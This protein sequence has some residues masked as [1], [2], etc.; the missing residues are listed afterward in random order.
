MDDREGG[1][2][3][4]A[5]MTAE[6]R[7][8]FVRSLGMAELE[9]LRAIIADRRHSLEAKLSDNDVRGPDGERLDHVAWNEWR[10]KAKAGLIAIEKRQRLVAGE[11]RDRNRAIYS[12]A[13]RQ[14]DFDGVDAIVAALFEV[15]MRLRKEVGPLEGGDMRTMSAARDYL[16]EA[17]RK[18]LK[19]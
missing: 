11:I 10:R 3:Y 18:R 17:R 15:V 4:D 13:V 12:D 19:G 6:D 2:I 9:E 7:P 14:E 8:G 1:A 16:V 5:L